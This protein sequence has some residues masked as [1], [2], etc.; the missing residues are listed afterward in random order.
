MAA[1][2]EK[3][4]KAGAT[5]NLKIF[6][7]SFNHLLSE[8]IAKK[9]GVGLSKVELVRFPDNETFVKIATAILSRPRGISSRPF[10][11]SSPPAR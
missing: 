2:K 9:A 11:I 10:F 6:A 8:R 4:S 3:T 5:K 7:G 1:T